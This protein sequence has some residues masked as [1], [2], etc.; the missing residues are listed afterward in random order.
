MLGLCSELRKTN[1]TRFTTNAIRVGQTPDSDYKAVINPIYQ[2]ATFAWQDLD[3]IPKVDY[4]RCANPN[5]L[6]LEQVLADLENGKFCVVYGSGMA[7]VIASLSLLK[8]GD[9]LL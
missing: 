3:T 1:I 9:H 7:A 5:R 8:S 4:T 2:S 6:V